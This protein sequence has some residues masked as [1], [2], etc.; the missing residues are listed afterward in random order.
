MSELELIPEEGVAGKYISTALDE[1][2]VLQK[3]DFHNNEHFNFAY[4][5]MDRFARAAKGAARGSYGGACYAEVQEVQES[6][7][8]KTVMEN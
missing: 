6:R 8:L 4:D 3:I 2:G 5:V 7:V 1:N